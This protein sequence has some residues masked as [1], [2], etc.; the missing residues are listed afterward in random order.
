MPFYEYV[1]PLCGHAFEQ[2]QKFSDAP[3]TTCPACKEASLQK[4]ISAPAF[5]LKGQ[6]WYVTD[7]KDSGKKPAA[8][9]K[10]PE[11]GAPSSAS[12]PAQTSE[13]VSEKP[14]TSG[15]KEAAVSAKITTPPETKS[16]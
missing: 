8:Q 4:K 1:C 9:E 3:L 7:F 10:T 16:S 12:A 13:A 6:G 2:L 15:E 11:G 14:K 5:H